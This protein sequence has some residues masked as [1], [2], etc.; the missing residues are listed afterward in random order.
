MRNGDARQRDLK[1]PRAEREPFPE[2]VV[3]LTAERLGI[4]AKATRISLLEALHE[5]EASVQELADRVGLAHQNASYHLSLLWK[6]GVLSRRCEG[7]MTLYA[8][9]DWSAWWVVEQ[10]ARWVQSSA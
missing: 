5:G 1:R 4:L 10:I 9:E 7:T 6:A 8:I 2:G 3:E